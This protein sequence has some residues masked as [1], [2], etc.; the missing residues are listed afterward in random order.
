LIDECIKFI[1][2][3]VGEAHRGRERH[4][5]LRSMGRTKVPYERTL[6]R[7]LPSRAVHLIPYPD[8]W[9]ATWYQWFWHLGHIMGIAALMYDRGEIKHRV[10]SGL[11]W[12]MDTDVDDTQFRD[13]AHIELVC[14]DECEH[15]N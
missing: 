2:F 13:A 3:S 8:G 12:D 6:H 14:T 15:S 9:D 5:R 7:F 10:R 4:E 1:D 11:D